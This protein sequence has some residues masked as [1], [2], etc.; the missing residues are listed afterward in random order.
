MVSYRRFL[1]APK[2]GKKE[3]LREIRMTLAGLEKMGNPKNP[4]GMWAGNKV[5][6]II[7]KKVRA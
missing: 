6:V 2:K 7:E 4:N 1:F 5:F 3:K